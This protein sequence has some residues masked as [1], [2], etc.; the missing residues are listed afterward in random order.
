MWPLAEQDLQTA[1]S[2]NPDAPEVLNYLGYSWIDRGLNLEEGMSLVRKALSLRPQSGEITDSLGWAHYKLGQF[3]KAIGYLERAVE[4]QPGIAEIN[5]HL[6]DA[7][8]AVGRST[9]ARYQ[10]ERAISL[11]E[12]EAEIERLRMKFLT[13]PTVIPANAQP[14]TP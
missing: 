6:G 9:E 10:W 7:Y 8:W 14:T 12:D 3:D 11:I 5:E 4:L 1:K 2:L 13:G